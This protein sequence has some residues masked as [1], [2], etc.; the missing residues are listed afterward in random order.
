MSRTLHPVL[1]PEERRALF[2]DGIRLF[3]RGEFFACHEAWEEIWRSTSPQPKDLFQ[4]LIQIGVGFY[5][6]FERKRPDVARRVL[7][8]GR[9]R[10][11]PFAPRTCGLDL[12]ALLAAVEAWEAWL[13]GGRGQPPPV[14]ELE[15]LDAEQVR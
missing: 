12:A 11:K 15:V 3:N 1:D 6:F 14:P 10:L 4:G 5:H 7:A 8:K 9:R 13:E 2:E